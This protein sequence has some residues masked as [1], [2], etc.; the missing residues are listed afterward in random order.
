VQEGGTGAICF[1]ETVG[2]I[3]KTGKDKEGLDR[4]CWILLGGNNGHQTRI[5][6]AYNPCKNKAVNSG[7][8]YQQQWW[9]YIMKKKDLTCPRKIFWRE[10][11]KQIKSWREAG[12]RI[13]LFMDHNKHVT[14]GPLGKELG[15]KNGLNIREAIIQHTG[16]S[17]G[18]TFSVD[19]SQ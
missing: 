16:A 19:Q 10:L 6:T 13:I 11:I 14:N 18:A 3:K 4:W 17:P 5:I 9:Y 12:D 1:G 7:T 8:T 15:D 2:Y